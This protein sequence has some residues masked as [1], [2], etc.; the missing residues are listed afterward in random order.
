[1]SGSNSVGSDP[2]SPT[3]AATSN[4]VRRVARGLRNSWAASSTKACCRSASASSRSSIPLRVVA[5]ERI[6]SRDSGTGSRSA[7]TSASAG[8]TLEG[9]GRRVNRPALA[10]APIRSAPSRSAST[11]ASAA[12]MTRQATAP[13]AARR[14]GRP[15]SSMV[16]TSPRL[17]S[18]SPVWTPAT[19]VTG[20]DPGPAATA[21]TCSRPASPDRE[22]GTVN[23]SPASA[24]PASSAVTSGVSRSATGDPA[25]TRDD[26]SS[27]CTT[28]AP[29]TGTGSLSRFWSTREATSRAAAEASDARVRLRV[30]ESTAY[31][32]VPAAASATARPTSPIVMSRHRMVSRRNHRG[33]AVTARSDSPRRAPSR[34]ARGRACAAGSPRRP[35]RH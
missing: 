9:R 17:T 5:R 33:P 25:T 13:S 11:G 7:G 35:R 22:P 32:R 19:T 21:A 34:P 1:M 26:P 14:T 20:A 31:M 30:A 18:T 2:P 27:T 23:A 6:S 12:P 28:S 24:R 8:T 29:D 15:T 4:W 3:C 10:S 16:R